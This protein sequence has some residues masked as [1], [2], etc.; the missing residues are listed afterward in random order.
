[1]ADLSS[2]DLLETFRVV[3]SRLNYEFV[4]RINRNIRQVRANLNF[5]C[6]E[7]DKKHDEFRPLNLEKPGAIKLGIVIE[8]GK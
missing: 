1:M 6:W 2:G 7:N 8:K 5:D 3:I 4:R